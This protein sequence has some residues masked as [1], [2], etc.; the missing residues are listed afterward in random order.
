MFLKCLLKGARVVHTPQTIGFYRLGD[1]TKITES[2]AGQARRAREWARFLLKAHEAC[3]T[4]GI[5]PVA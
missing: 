1:E 3:S 4:Q 5:A 2:K